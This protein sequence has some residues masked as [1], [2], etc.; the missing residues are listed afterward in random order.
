MKIKKSQIR[1]LIIESISKEYLYESL[2]IALLTGCTRSDCH[3]YMLSPE[4]ENLKIPDCVTK[5][6]YPFETLEFPIEYG[7]FKDLMEGEGYTVKKRLDGWNNGEDIHITIKNVPAKIVKYLYEMRIFDDNPFAG[8]S[9]NVSEIELCDFNLYF[10]V[11]YKSREEKYVVKNSHHLHNLLTGESAWWDDGGVC[12]STSVKKCAD[13]KCNK[14][15]VAVVKNID[16]QLTPEKEDNSVRRTNES[17]NPYE[18]HGNHS[19]KK[20]DKKNTHLDKPTSH[21]YMSGENKDWLQKGP[22]NKLIYD[23]LKSMGMI[24]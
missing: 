6:V 23:Y 20:A 16:P 19:Y 21:S 11:Y 5:E 12:H 13:T 15:F 10:P 14:D 24:K 4:L 1:R 2:L 9:D 8:F 7:E 18:K 17:Y 3:L 22:V